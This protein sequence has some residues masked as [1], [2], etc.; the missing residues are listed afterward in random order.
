MAEALCE[1]KK[2]SSQE[3]LFEELSAIHDAYKIDVDQFIGF[4][5]ERRLRLVEGIKPYVEWLDQ[6]HAGKLY[7]PATINRKI[8]AAKSRIRFAFKHSTS[9]GSLRKKYQLEEVLESVKAKRID[10]I[11]VP[12]EKVLSIE[13]V[14]KMVRDT[15]D[16]TIKHMVNFLV[17]TGVRISEMLSIRLADIQTASKNFVSVRIAGKDHKERE[18]RVK[19]KVV[20][21]IRNYFH[22]TTYLF[23]HHGKQYSRIS[24]TNRIKHESLR[25]IGKEVSAQQLRHTWAV[26]QIQRGKAIGTVAAALGH[27]DPALTARMYSGETDSPPEEAFLDIPEQALESGMRKKRSKKKQLGKS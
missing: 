27:S 19:A 11:A 26:V 6:E 10:N 12:A 13:E 24:V 20:D 22:G 4:L 9:A 16:V 8:A 17:G 14:A 21:R 25:T 3:K 15:K 2:M 23:E 5:R 7:S 18:I 1:V